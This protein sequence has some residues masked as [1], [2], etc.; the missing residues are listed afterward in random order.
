MQQLSGQDASF[1]YFETANAP[2]HIGSFALYDPSTAG[3]PLSYD[4]I[5]HNTA[6]RLHRARCFRQRVVRVPLDLD[7]PYWIEDP[8]FDLE[9]HVRHI[10]LPK[11]G[12]WQQLCTQVARLQARPL[13]LT[14]PLWELYVIEGLENIPG[15]PHGSF[16]LLTKIHHAAIDGVSGAELAAAIHDLAPDSEPPLPDAPWAPDELPSARELLLKTLGH[17]AL[18]PLKLGRLLLEAVP[19]A[20]RAREEQRKHPVEPVG[21]PRTRFN[22]P[23]SP[24]RSVGGVEL[25]L[26]LVRE[27]KKSL[28]GATV[29]DAILT[30]V[31]GALRRYLEAKHELPEHALVAMAPI[32]ARAAGE[33]GAAGNRVSVMTVGLGSDV[34]DPAE[35]LRR[36]HRKAA[37]SKAFNQ[38]VGSRLMTDVQEVIP[39]SLAGLVARIFTGFGLANRVDPFFNCVVTNVPGP[40]FPLYSAG[41]RLVANYGLGPIQDGLGLIHPIFSYCG[42][43][44]VAFTAC[45]AMLPD[46]RF[47]EDC[48]RA[49]FDDLRT[50]TL[51][52]SQELR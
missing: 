46:P 17:R 39:G 47:Y 44:T 38:A 23:V 36:V 48:L 32:S 21:V 16:A 7:H 33:Q 41:A 31:G 45:R 43:I 34:A 50:A 6:Q 28:P 3:G 30:I 42:R 35:R 27:I 24:H 52:P 29:N 51:G 40:Q 15:L 1:L 11:P 37:G 49:S 12:D 10:A 22:G 8:D 9:F 20:V 14:R 2:M 13:D 4:K 25:D 18:G 5:V 26:G 19:A